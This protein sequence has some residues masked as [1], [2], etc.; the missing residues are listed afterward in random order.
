MPGVNGCAAVACIMSS[1][2]QHVASGSSG[3]AAP[4]DELLLFKRLV[5]QTLWQDNVFTDRPIWEVIDESFE[6]LAQCVI[7]FTYTF[8]EVLVMITNICSACIRCKP[9][10]P[11]SAQRRS[12]MRRGQDSRMPLAHARQRTCCS[13][14]WI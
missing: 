3:H 5:F 7:V 1:S 12:G 10:D 13:S 6:A 9:A 2:Q 8:V 4:N 14:V 11:P